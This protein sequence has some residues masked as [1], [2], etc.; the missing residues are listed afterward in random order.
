MIG[1]IV[2][3]STQGRHLSAK[4]GFLVVADAVQEVARVP[5]DDI[6]ALVITG[7]G[8]T[9]S[10]EL[11]SRLAERGV[12]TVI[13]GRGF[14]PVAIVWPVAAHY[15]QSGILKLQA[16]MSARIRSRL[17]T[18]IVVAKIRSQAA[19]LEAAGM[20]HMPITRLVGQVTL[21]DP[22]N[23]EA[24]AARKYWTLLFGKQFRRNRS[25]EGI[26]ALLN[27]GYAVVR[28]T[29]ARGVTAT[30]LHPGIGFYH[31]SE[32]NSFQLVDDLIEPYRPFVD[33]V[34]YR[35]GKREMTEVTAETKAE[36]VSVIHRDIE[37]GEYTS[38]LAE[39][40]QRTARS[41]VS[42]LAKEH[43]DLALPAT[44]ASCMAQVIG[45]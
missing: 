25:A 9:Q 42:V 7:F 16:A 13:C 22:R 5:L 34:V 3:I 18:Q 10:S 24:Q 38:P 29:A 1:K 2:E 41:V 30:G 36:L 39:W 27:Y 33:A 14:S 8:C 11:L 45:C 43:K 35:L 20:P 12:A 6:S 40:L 17:W 21:G 26:N 32:L 4:R 37:C 44:N 15:R 23:I 31:R 19:L 28:A